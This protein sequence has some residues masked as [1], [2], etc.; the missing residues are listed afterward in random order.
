MLLMERRTPSK[1]PTTVV[2]SV[3]NA[4]TATLIQRLKDYDD[5]D[6]TTTTATCSP[7]P[8]YAGEAGGGGGY[9]AAYTTR[10]TVTAGEGRGPGGGGTTW[11]ASGGEGMTIA[12]GNYGTPG[13]TQTNC[14]TAADGSLLTCIAPPAGSN[15]QTVYGLLESTTTTNGL[16][17]QPT[18]VK[19]TVDSCIDFRVTSTT[20][21]GSGRTGSIGTG[22]NR[23]DMDEDGF[24][25]ASEFGVGC[26]SPHCCNIPRSPYFLYSPHCTSS[27]VQLPPSPR[28][29]DQAFRSQGGP[30]EGGGGETWTRLGGEHFEQVVAPMPCQYTTY[31]NDC[32]ANAGSLTETTYFGKPPLSFNLNL[33]GGVTYMPSSVST[34][35]RRSPPPNDSTTVAGN[36]L[37][38][39]TFANQRYLPTNGNVVTSSAPSD[40]SRQPSLTYSKAINPNLFGNNTNS[41]NNNNL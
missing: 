21:S 24:G 6:T 10:S 18:D 39:S 1:L 11:T 8:G 33:R 4:H 23:E 5:T 34:Y 29:C 19:M 27:A 15:P 9:A 16:E 40:R 30:E 17:L 37:L 3:R 41:T 36:F 31:P 14:R 25:R 7:C 38:T 35:E 12:S 20:S 28:S 32:K 2:C 13:T 26:S 22:S